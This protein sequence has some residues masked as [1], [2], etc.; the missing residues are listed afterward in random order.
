[1]TVTPPAAQ[2]RSP[3]AP[4]SSAAVLSWPELEKIRSLGD[5]NV[6]G[7]VGWETTANPGKKNGNP[8]TSADDVGDEGAAVAKRG[9]RGVD[10]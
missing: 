9:R 7:E 1:M 10:F 8:K 4:G 5:P 2:A 6:G 3:S